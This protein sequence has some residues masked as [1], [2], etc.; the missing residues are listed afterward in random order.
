LTVPLIS[1]IVPTHNRADLLPATVR[2][3]LAQTFRDFE[4]IVVD[5]GS[6]DKTA[7]ALEPFGDR[8][9]YVYQQ[10]A[11]R[12]AARNHG[13]R[14]ATGKYVTFLDSDDLWTPTKLA[15]EVAKFEA[16]PHLGLVY[17]DAYYIDL[18]GRPIGPVVRR[19]HEGD[20]LETI[21]CDNFVPSGAQL[22]SRERFLEAGGFCEDRRLSGS[23]DWE[24]W[25]R[26]AAL[27]PFAHVRNRG[28]L[29]RIH[30]DAS[31]A[32][33]RAMERSI[34][35]A[36]ELMFDNPRLR[37]RIAHLR[38]RA[39]ASTHLVMA[40]LYYAAHHADDVRRHLALARQV[41]PRCV[42]DRRY[43]GMR[44]RLAAGARVMGSLRRCRRLLAGKGPSAR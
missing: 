3:V 42:F 24:A 8:L 22:V 2:S 28:Q 40:S 4:L 12:G 44:L 25:V 19:A 23:E 33:P 38:G 13:L 16:H 32:Q 34:L 1:V 14:L 39:Y 30:G 21:V 15:A 6:K 29:Y 20:V 31:V 17:S 5:D 43:L 18:D 10:N 7:Q 26:L 41:D 11:E 27:A 37:P 35:Y 9:R 36:R